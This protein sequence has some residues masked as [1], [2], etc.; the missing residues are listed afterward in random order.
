MCFEE[1]L[2]GSRKAVFFLEEAY[3]YDIL[4]CSARPQKALPRKAMSGLIFFPNVPP[5]PTKLNT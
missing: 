4:A 2:A 3:R 5:I 1:T